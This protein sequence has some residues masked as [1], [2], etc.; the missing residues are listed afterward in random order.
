MK[1]NE[2]F[3]E[4]QRELTEERKTMA[5]SVIKERLREIS[6][7]RKILDKMGQ[8]LNSLLSRNL[9]DPEEIQ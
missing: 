2:L 4:A 8:Q 7:T 5:K 9:D 1:L 6:M 3:D